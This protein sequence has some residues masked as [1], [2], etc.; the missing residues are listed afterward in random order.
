MSDFSA[1]LEVVLK[2][3]GGYVND[4]ADAGGE[5][6]WGISLRFLE[7]EG[8]VPQDVGLVGTEWS[9]GLLRQLTRTAAGALYKACFWDR[10][11]CGELLNQ[12][13]ATKVFDAFVNMQPATA[14]KLAQRAAVACGQRCDVDGRM[15]PET[16]AAINACGSEQFTAAMGGQ[17]EAFYRGL[18][19]AKPA[20]AKFLKSWLRRAA[21][22]H[23]PPATLEPK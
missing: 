6:N 22:P 12:T 5:T 8:L 4:P 14:A 18:V 17:Q 16:V 23:I 13:V 15:G 1:A 11:R 7:R 10:Y 2:H 3:E 19:A 21:W 20:Q 9:P